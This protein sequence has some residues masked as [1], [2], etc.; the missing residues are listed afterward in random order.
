MEI[1]Q[2]QNFQPLTEDQIESLVEKAIDRLDQQL[3]TGKITPI[4]YENEVSIVDKWSIQQY[5]FIQN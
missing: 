4:E 5:K 2:M 3:L 1:R